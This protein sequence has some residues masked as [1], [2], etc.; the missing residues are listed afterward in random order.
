MALTNGDETSGTVES[1]TA[2][3]LRVKCDVG[4]L[5]V[6]LTRALM[7]EFAGPPVPAEEGIRF[8]LAGKG[9]LTVKSFT[10]ADGKVVCHSATAGD[11]S[12][13][14]AAL[15]E[16][17]FQPRNQT[18]PA[19]PGTGDAGKSSAPNGIPNI[20]IQGGGIIRGNINF[21]GIEGGRINIR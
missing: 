20:I 13:P 21:N 9:T 4:T 1:A 10:L 2:E 11:L 8:R 14:V 7:A 17:V 6:P 18:P 5:D 15:S 19:N 16:I 12:F 3:V